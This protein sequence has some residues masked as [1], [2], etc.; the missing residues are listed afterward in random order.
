MAITLIP[1]NPD[2]VRMDIKMNIP[3][4]DI[5]SFLQMRGYEIKAFV[6]VIPAEES[7]LLSEPRKEIHTFTATKPWQKQCENTLYLTTFEREVKYL[8]KDI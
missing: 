5:I 8:L 7:M 4:G 1:V 2:I 6:Q 3:Q